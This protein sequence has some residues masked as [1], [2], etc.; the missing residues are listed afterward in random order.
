[1]AAFMRY[2]VQQLRQFQINIDTC[3]GRGDSTENSLDSSACIAW[4]I[5]ESD[6]RHWSECLGLDTG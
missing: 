5:D 3:I 6:V 2:V 4:D 1:M